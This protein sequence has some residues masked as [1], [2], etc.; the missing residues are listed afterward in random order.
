MAKAKQLPSGSWRCRATI[1]DSDG[2]KITKS[3]TA[4]TARKAET[5]ASMWQEG[6]IACE[7][8]RAAH[9][10][11]LGEAIDNYIETC[12]CAGMSP[13]TIRGYL[14]CRK[15]AYTLIE[16][17]TIRRLTVQD[18]QRQLNARSKTCSP[19]TLH[20]NLSLLTATLK[21]NEIKLDF[22]ALRLPKKEKKEMKIPS[23]AQ[24]I[25]LLDTLR[26]EDDQMYIAV[27]LA[28]IMGLR[29]SEI[30]ALTWDDIVSIN[31]KH[32]LIISKASVFDEHMNL[33]EKST[34]TDAGKR[35][36]QIPDAV[37]SEL[38]SRRTL[39][40]SIVCINPNMITVRFRKYANRI[41][42]PV[43]F[44]D[45]RHYHASVMV[46]EGVP[47]KYIASDMGH[48]SFEMVRRVYAH[49]M[50]EKLQEIEPV[51][52]YHADN[53]LLI[54]TKVDTRQKIPM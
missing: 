51:M 44:H 20:N 12:R 46:R 21:A 39:R 4:D 41:G 7:K 45:L 34:K 15:N 14:A 53:V 6:F 28:S 11:S 16:N 33:V 50:G 54:D 36:L 24:L 22:K 2:N 37:L 17:K 35:K 30:C 47:E 52:E 32:Y 43:R 25:K 42:I 8:D 1:T 9:G 3:F 40:K 19:K 27:I 29:R 13:A 38:L 18:I 49:V 48:S 26:N 10:I 31:G 5:M 23:D